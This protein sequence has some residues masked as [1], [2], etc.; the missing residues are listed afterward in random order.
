MTEEDKEKKEISAIY[1][2]KETTLS[3][4]TTGTILVENTNGIGE[5]KRHLRAR[6]LQMIALGG[7]IGTGF[8]IGSGTAFVNGGPVGILIGF[9]CVGLVVY[10]TMLSLG[11]M[12]TFLP[13]AGGFTSLATRFVDPAFGFAMGWNYCY[14]FSITLPAELSAAAI[15]VGYW[16]TSHK[17]LALWITLFYLAIMVINFMDVRYYG[18]FEFW[19]SVIKILTIIALIFFGFLMPLGADADYRPG[20][21]EYWRN[22]GAIPS[23]A[24][25]KNANLARFVGVWA[26][27]VQAAF[28]YLGTEIV[29]VTA[30]E[31]RNPRKTVPIAIKRVF[32]RILIFYVLGSFAIGLL[33]P[34]ND[35]QLFEMLVDGVKNANA[36]P[37]VIAINRAGIPGLP[38][39]LNAVI[40]ISA[41]SAGNSDVYTSSR[42]LYALALENKAPRIFLACTK[43]GIPYNAIIGT[44][45]LGF[46]S[47]LNCSSATSATVFNWFVSL[48]T[49]S[50]LITWA[51]ICI[52]YLRFY[53]GLKAQGI[54]RNTLPW[55]SPFQPFSAWFGLFWCTFIVI[56][57][58]YSSFRT[59][60]RASKFLTAYIG[61]P[62]FFGL[63]LFWKFYKK[64]KH[65]PANEMDFATG[66][67]ELDE[68]DDEGSPNALERLW[69]KLC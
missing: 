67:K 56:F 47:Y 63:Y 58:G 52:T 18:E 53:A 21:F 65:I 8:F 36:S 9:S 12:I 2:N 45:S 46:L 40:L 13:T 69:S 31:A 39:V 27:F 23:S 20:G 4:N 25:R 32:F 37:F 14:G 6:H 7:T 49:V 64:T 16:N 60:F 24:I 33:L 19:F 62:F 38:S 43:N 28:S 26:V 22:P 50:G 5:T 48:S 15:V 42:T 59:P 11:E 55:K 51:C 3:D 29:A 57:N 30:G 41:W 35:P 66:Q 68:I 34:Y 1:S 54:D 61:V 44:G 10:A 17:L